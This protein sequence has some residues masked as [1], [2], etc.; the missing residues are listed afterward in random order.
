MICS[1]HHFHK[2]VKQVAGILRS[3]AGF[4]MEL[5]GKDIFTFVSHSFVCTIV[6]IDKCRFCNTFFLKGFRIN[7][8]S[9]VLR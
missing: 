3:R 9:M 7:H 8:V 4:R 5:Y 1:S 2:S 6:Y